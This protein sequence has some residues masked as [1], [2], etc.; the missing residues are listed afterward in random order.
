[1]IAYKVVH[2]PSRYGSNAA[3]YIQSNNGNFSNFK[4]LLRDYPQL[5]PFFPVYNKGK[6][7]RAAKRTSGIICFSNISEANSFINYEYLNNVMIIKVRGIGLRPRPHAIFSGCGSWPLELTNPEGFP[8]KLT[9]INW[10][11]FSAVEVLE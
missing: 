7:V 10:L 1:M 11:F 6:I 3:G 2:D 4:Y 9:D 5:R 8:D